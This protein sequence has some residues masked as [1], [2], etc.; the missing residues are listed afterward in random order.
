MKS[1]LSRILFVATVTGCSASDDG[2]WFPAEDPGGKADAFTTIRGSDIPSSNVDANKQ[3]MLA[4]RIDTLEMAGAFDMTQGPLSRRI[5]G[6]IANMPADGRL[7]LAELVRMETPAI[8]DSLFPAEKAALPQLWKMMEAPDTNHSLVGTGAA[9]GVVDDSLQPGPAVLPANMQIATLAMD[10]QDPARR[11][12]N[13][14]NADANAATVQYPD[15]EKGV[16]NPG[17][18]TPAEIAV[19]KRLQVMFREQAVANS[20]VQLV[21]SPVPGTYTKDEMLGPIK[22][23]VDGVTKIDEER[24]WQP[25]S[26][27]TTRLTATQTQV[28]TATMPADAKLV[29]INKQGAAEVA[30]GSGVVG[31][32]SSQYVVEMWQNGNRTFST[33]MQ[34]PALTRNDTVDITSNLDYTLSSGLAPLVR[35]LTTA[36]FVGNTATIKATYDKTTIPPT[37]P[38]NQTAVQRTA[39]P[40]V[41]IATGRYS[42]PTLNAI[43]YVHPN[44]VLWIQRGTQM[45]RM[46]PYYGDNT[47]VYSYFAQS[48]QIQFDVRTNVLYNTQNGQQ[49]VLDAS[50][51]DI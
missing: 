6:I 24:S 35:N 7:H 41:K 31:I 15:L 5:D 40:V 49:L 17:A 20:T 47:A 1:L 39:S 4:R 12:Q 43:L 44:N 46:L 3:Y 9:F 2:I 16:A 32:A 30:S 25:S 33:N 34:T 26:Q 38:I 23:H 22:F 36:T 27:M 37:Q 48:A 45:F 51:R 18:F 13:L 50:M 28:A 21:V 42:V 14:Y 29:L 8:F 11:L 10:L 19:F